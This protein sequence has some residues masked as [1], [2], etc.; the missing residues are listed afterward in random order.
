MAL[1]SKNNIKSVFIVP[2]LTA[3]TPGSI[4][5]PGSTG[6]TSGSVVIT[7]MSNQVL[8]TTATGSLAAWDPTFFDKIKIVKD[9]GANLPLQQVVLTRSQVIGASAVAGKLAVE[10]VSYIGYN[11]STGAMDTT[12]N[13]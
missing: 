3:I 5:T 6:A 7:S 9:R 4:I 13:N 12:I 8:A 10:Q 2:S 1:D 11:G